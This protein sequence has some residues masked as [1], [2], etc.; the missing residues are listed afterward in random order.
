MYVR[1]GNGG[2]G[3]GTDTARQPDVIY[4]NASMSQNATANIA[5]TQM[6]KVIELVSSNS[7]GS[8]SCGVYNVDTQDGWL[9]GYWSSS[10]QSQYWTAASNYF[11]SITSSNIAFKNAGFSGTSRITVAVYY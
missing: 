2:G 5:V 4:Q 9:F 8:A 11:T 1:S 6:P 10:M 3:S 7:S